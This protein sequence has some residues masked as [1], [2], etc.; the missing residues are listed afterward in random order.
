[1]RPGPLDPAEVKRF[2]ESFLY[3]EQAFLVDEVVAVDREARA[4][5]ALLDTTRELPFA[6]AQRTGPG[7][8]AHVAAGEILM[9]TGSLGFLS[10]WLFHGVRWDEGWVGF[11]TR[12]HRADWKALARIGPPLELLSREVRWRDQPRRVVT[13]LEF[14]FSQQG[15]LVYAGDQ[16]AMF[17]RGA[18]FE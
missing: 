3:R 9:A 14:R 10:A 16:S 2:L 6:R 15:R 7:H 18:T 12:V 4:I 8:P 13:R 11:G 17:L 1:M 5:R